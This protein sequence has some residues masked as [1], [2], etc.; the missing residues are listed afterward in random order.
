VIKRIFLDLDDVL[1]IFTPWALQCVFRDIHLDGREY[2]PIWGFDIVAAANG[3]PVTKKEWDLTFTPDSFWK[4]I[5]RSVWSCAPLSDEFHYLIHKSQEAVGKEN[6]F[7]LTTPMDCPESAAGKVEW[8][9][10]YCPEWLHRQFLI[11]PPKWV[12]AHESLLFDDSDKNVEAFRAAGGHTCLVP[13]P[14]NSNHGKSSWGRI[15]GTFSILS[16]AR[17]RHA[18]TEL[19]V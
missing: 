6:V 7:I 18:S 5:E 1:N 15:E 2:N 17:A 14:W 10:A 8:I 9:Q 13:R 4:S 12:C 16:M 11:G 3:L 19:R